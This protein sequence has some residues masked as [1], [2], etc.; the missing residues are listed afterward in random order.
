MPKFVNFHTHKIPA[1]RTVLSLGSHLK[2]QEAY[3]IKWTTFGKPPVGLKSHTGLKL[4]SQLSNTLF[5]L[6]VPTLYSLQGVLEVSGA[7]LSTYL[8]TFLL[9]LAIEPH[10]PGGENLGIVG[11][12]DHDGQ[13]QEE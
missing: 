1:S 4:R 6:S 7:I 10:G 11:K 9:L 12:Q 8:D 2:T 3:F 5:H 13:S